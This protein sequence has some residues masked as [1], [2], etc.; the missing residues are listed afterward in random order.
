[1]TLAAA[2]VG[3]MRNS[4]ASVLLDDFNRADSASLA[5]GPVTWANYR[6]GSW[7]VSTNQAYLSTTSGSGV[8]A[9]VNCAKA[10]GKVGATLSTLASSGGLG[11]AFRV[12]DGNNLW[13]IIAATS[14]LTL[15][16]IVA[17]G[18]TSV[19][20]GFGSV[21]SGDKLEVV[22][23]GSSISIFV[24]GTQRGTTVTDSTFSTATSHG[25][26]GETSTAARVDNWS[27]TP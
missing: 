11:L 20:S 2:R 18:F 7:G 5:G 4:A 12:Q 21:S 15:Y 10:D 1:M 27:F 3:R 16:K 14:A 8:V 23:S 25:M 17:N 26:Y 24:N 6:S 9:A 22:L 13:I 19:G